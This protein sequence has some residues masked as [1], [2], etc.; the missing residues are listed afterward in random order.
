[1]TVIRT[2][3]AADRA[4]VVDSLASAFSEDPLFTWMSAAGQKRPLEPKMRIL[5]DTFL[6]L[7]LA[8]SD[9]LVFTDEDRIGAAIWKHPNRWK[10]PTGDMVRALP[11]MLRALGTKAPKMIGAITALEKVHPIEEHYYLEVLGT[12]QDKQSKGIGSAVMGH[13]LDRCDTEG[14]PAYL[15]SSNPRNIPF[16]ARHGF[17]PT[18]EIVVGKGAP[19]VTAMWRKPR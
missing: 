7:D 6:K 15:E 18:G 9:H 16:Y 10:M 8:R 1:M 2:A 5:F 4:K 12:H 13:M 17:E 19:T 14:M 3:T 11:G